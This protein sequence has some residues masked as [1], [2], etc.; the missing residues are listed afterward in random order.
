MAFVFACA[1][2]VGVHRPL[3]QGARPFT[4][5]YGRRPHSSFSC[6]LS[7]SA[8]CH[9]RHKRHIKHKKIIEADRKTE[10]LFC[11]FV[12]YVPFVAKKRVWPGPSWSPYFGPN[13]TRNT[14]KFPLALLSTLCVWRRSL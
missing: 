7:L 1:E 14:G 6:L 12:P 13:H 4:R 5:S 2:R 9:I 10:L 8:Y 3:Q 11:A